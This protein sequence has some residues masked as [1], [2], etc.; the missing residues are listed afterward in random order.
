M[1]LFRKT[2]DTILADVNKKIDQL[3]LLADQEKIHAVG[4]RSQANAALL[5]AA[6]SEKEADR[7]LRIAEKI[8]ALVA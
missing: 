7:A 1:A 2:V 8:E 3:Q 5:A 6:E 4:L